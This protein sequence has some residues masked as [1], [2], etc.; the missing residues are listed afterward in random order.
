MILDLLE[1]SSHTVERNDMFDFLQHKKKVND[2]AF[3][4]WFGD[5]E[6]SDQKMKMKKKVKNSSKSGDE[7]DKKS[8][9]ALT[10]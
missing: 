1:I 8:N 5:R 9:V 6:K 4:K 3:I 7:K 2:F 10:N